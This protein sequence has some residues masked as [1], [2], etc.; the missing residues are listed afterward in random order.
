MVKIPQTSSEGE[1]GEFCADIR[2]LQLSS[3]GVIV[4]LRANYVLLYFH[5]KQSDVYSQTLNP[6]A[7][8]DAYS[9][10]SL[11]LNDL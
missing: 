8:S 3:C 1:T 7:A 2:D 9:L 5:V 4:S 6:E 11:C 10:R